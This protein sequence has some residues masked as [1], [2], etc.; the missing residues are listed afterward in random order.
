MK[1]YDAV[2]NTII[3]V[4]PKVGQHKLLW[5]HLSKPNGR[6]CLA[7]EID[8]YAVTPAREEKP[9]KVVE[10]IQPVANFQAILEKELAALEAAAEKEQSEAVGETEPEV[11]IEVPKPKR[12]RPRKNQTN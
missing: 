6:Y 3:T 12:G 7:H 9:K 5:R 10:Q 4:S 11:E 1:I 2:T 8:K